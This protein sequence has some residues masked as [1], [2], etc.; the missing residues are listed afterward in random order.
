MS[1]TLYL[2]ADIVAYRAA[3]AAENPIDWGNGE[4][5]LH[6]FEADV[7][8]LMELFIDQLKEQSGITNVVACISDK[9]NF[10]KEVASYYKANR[11]DTRKPMLL[12]YA[13]TYLHNKYKGMIIPKLEA[14]DVLGIMA[15]T[16]PNCVIWSLDKD[17]LTI[18]GRHFIDGELVEI[19][20]DE[21]DR[22]F[23]YQ[24]LVGDSTD[25]YSGCPKVGPKKA[26]KILEDSEDYWA[27]TVAAF[28]KAGLN[29]DVAIENARL[30]RIL[31]AEDFNAE[32]RE[33]ILWNPS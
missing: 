10:R 21:A 31:R 17:L 24:T 20:Q 28:E 27:S 7:E 14:D 19:T 16:D 4:W 5:T 30:A 1:D 11:K 29:E 23:Y 26:E 9:Q 22:W 8:R 25:N 12:N 6:S 2:D 32:T 15:G 3:A 18:P 13:K 33:V